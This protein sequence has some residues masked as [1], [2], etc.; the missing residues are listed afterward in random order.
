MLCCWFMKLPSLAN[1]N[2]ELHI[3]W[4]RINLCFQKIMLC[5]SVNFTS[6]VAVGFSFPLYSLVQGCGYWVY[7]KQG[8]GACGGATLSFMMTM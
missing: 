6:S 3:F 1:L 4:K 7:M 2:F 8:M 5:D